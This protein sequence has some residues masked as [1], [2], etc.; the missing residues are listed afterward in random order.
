MPF[1]EVQDFVGRNPGNDNT[2][3]RVPS[4]K[5]GEFPDIA[6]VGDSGVF[7]SGAGIRE[8]ICGC[9]SYC[10]RGD[11]NILQGMVWMSTLA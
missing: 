11:G 10:A 3:A 1:G 9:C 5:A 2:I 4:L 6:T 8:R 7:Q